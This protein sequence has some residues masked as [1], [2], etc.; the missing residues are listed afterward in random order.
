MKRPWDVVDPLTPYDF[1]PIPIKEM[2]FS[3]ILENSCTFSR[4]ELFKTVKLWTRCYSETVTEGY[5]VLD[6]L[7]GGCNLELMNNSITFYRII[8]FGSLNLLI[9]LR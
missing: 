1:F 9:N 3:P 6:D 2:I 7:H 5:R 8:H 4:E